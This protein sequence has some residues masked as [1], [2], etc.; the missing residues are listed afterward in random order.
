MKVLIAL[1]IVF[2]LIGIMFIPIVEVCVEIETDKIVAVLLD[3]SVS[4]AAAW[5]SA[6]RMTSKMW[7]SQVSEKLLDKRSLDCESIDFSV[8]VYSS[9]NR[10]AVMSL[11]NG[12]VLMST[13]METVAQ[14]QLA[15]VFYESLNKIF[16]AFKERSERE[17]I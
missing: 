8:E 3:K 6:L 5:A 17:F 15:F 1:L 4:F 16:N 7:G 2:V 12:T 13:K 10:N 14:M 11:D 9:H